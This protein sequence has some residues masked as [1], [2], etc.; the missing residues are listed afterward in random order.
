MEF[1]NIC[2]IT[3]KNISE[4][5]DP[6]ITPDGYTY[7]R[8]EL[9]RWIRQNGTDPMTRNLLEISQLVVNRAVQKEIQ[10][11][12]KPKETISE[13][14]LTIVWDISGSMSKEASFINEDG[15]KENSG[16]SY[17]DIVRH[18]IS[19][20]INVLSENHRLSIVTFS[21]NTKL[22]L[23]LTWMNDSGKK[24]ALEKIKHIKTSGCTDLW[25]GIF[26]GL[27]NNKHGEIYVL[28]DGIPSFEPPR[29][30]NEQMLK[31][32][33]FHPDH[34]SV[35]KTF[36]FGY[37]LDSKLLQDIAH[38]FEGSFSFIP[39]AGF[40]GTVFIHSLVNS[41]ISNEI[42]NDKKIDNFLQL[43]KSL[44]EST[45][46]L[47]QNLTYHRNIIKLYKDNYPGGI[48]EEQIDIGCSN[49][50]YYHKWGKHYL[51]SLFDAHFYQECNNFKDK[52]VQ[53]YAT[54]EQKKLIDKAEEIFC[55][56]PTPEPSISKNH[57]RSLNVGN[58][59]SNLTTTMRSFSQPT[60][61]CF[62][63]ECRI[64]TQDGHKLIRNL[65]KGDMLKTEN[66]Y[67]RL[68]CVMKTISPN[69]TNKLVELDSK[70]K[71]DNLK[72][73]NIYDDL[74]SLE[75]IDCEKTYSLGGIDSDI[76]PDEEICEC[77]KLLVTEWHPIK[78]QNDWT[79][80]IN[81]HKSKV[82]NIPYV[83]SFVV[84]NS[85]T[86]YIEGWECITLGHKIKNDSVASHDFW[87]TEKVIRCLKI[88]PG[89]EKGEVEVSEC[90]RDDNNQ[91]FFLI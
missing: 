38:H 61:G 63:G 43:I 30:W 60:G 82:H 58:T 21:T 48:F 7:E 73:S 80:P 35:V 76:K 65:K 69:G 89:W 29:G 77:S 9:E 50:D 15:N 31:Y 72:Y 71:L 4:L 32:K 53:N 33:E 20:I 18:A 87:G 45:S 16:L 34:S 84:E 74:P 19:V 28:T 44:I 11:I 51:R 39:D 2:P 22:V 55:N 62:S 86:I 42:K 36:G 13:K 14:D 3:R 47:T 91:V 52:S 56:L 1:T 17:H 88:K 5:T 10:K 90:V 24:N 26:K 6:V 23:P 67:N 54:P 8:K 75:C 25:G 59:T 81:I 85:T 66:G 79:F 70:L 57:Y 27:Q 37:S 46:E 64:E 40:V 83:Y 12:E 49:Y 68:I 78:H 41:L